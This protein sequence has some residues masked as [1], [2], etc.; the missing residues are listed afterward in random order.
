MTTHNAFRVPTILVF[1]LV[2]ALG[3]RPGAA[4][5]PADDDPWQLRFGGV[6]V[7]S[8]LT[9]ATTDGS[10]TR[11]SGRS[12]SAGGGL[13]VSAEY[14]FSQRLGAEIGLIAAADFTIRFDD[15]Y[16]TNT[17]AFDAITGGLNVHLSPDRA[18]D[19]YVGP[20]FAYIRYEDLGYSFEPGEP[21][22]QVPWWPDWVPGSTA[23]LIIADDFAFGVN[24]GLDVRFRGT[25]WSVSTAFKYLA[26]NVDATTSWG[27]PAD[28]DIDPLIV[29]LGAGYRF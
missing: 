1:A 15:P 25:G 27:D 11:T 8:G 4:A 26:T 19:V 10:G 28:V 20:L 17:L 13:G 2:L 7:E 3:T 24:L 18:V 9:F 22:A 16:A 5:A 23:Y 6:G 21:V 14:R 29:S 12:D